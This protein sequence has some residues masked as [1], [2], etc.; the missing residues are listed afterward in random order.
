MPWRVCLAALIGGGVIIGL[1]ALVHTPI[2]RM[3]G[4][5]HGIDQP[6]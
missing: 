4:R 6:Q 5:Q 2:P 1:A 3:D